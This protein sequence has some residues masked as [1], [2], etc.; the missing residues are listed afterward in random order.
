[1]AIKTSSDFP[2]YNLRW[3]N[4]F[5]PVVLKWGLENHWKKAIWYIHSLEYDS[6][7]NRN[8]TMNKHNNMHES[9]AKSYVSK[10]LITE[11]G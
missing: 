8:K 6:A 1:M 10:C 4:V 5:L 2:K 7:V 11:M 3:G 9:K